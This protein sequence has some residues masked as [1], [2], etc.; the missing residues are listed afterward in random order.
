MSFRRFVACLSFLFA[1]VI[2]SRASAESSGRGAEEAL[3][4]AFADT[5]I[6]LRVVSFRG[7]TLAP[8]GDTSQGLSIRGADVNPAIAGNMMLGAGLRVGPIVTGVDINLALGG[9]AHGPEIQAGDIR[10]RPSGFAAV[11]NL[12]T[13]LGVLFRPNR[14]MRL[15]LEATLGT[16]IAGIGMERPGYPDTSVSAFNADRITAGP[17]VR[18]EWPL[19][20]GG[21]GF[22]FVLGFDA[23]S[24]LNSYAGI[25]ISTL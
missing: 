8:G 25:V 18:V 21:G 24:P 6:G 9:L 19:G 11:A 1:F 3:V 13:Y 2:A 17:R 22:G 23:R 7:L 5:G 20:F 16:E 12:G 10:I 4:S 14:D 15:R